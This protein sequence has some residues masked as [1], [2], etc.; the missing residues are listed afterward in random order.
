MKPIDP[1]QSNHTT[2]PDSYE[3]YRRRKLWKTI[4]NRVLSRD[5]Q[6]MRCTGKA[7]VVHHRSYAPEVMQGLADEYL[8]S[9]CHG[10]HTVVEFDDSGNYRPWQE[11]ESVLLTPDTGKDFPEPEVDLRRSYTPKPLGWERMSNLRQVG[12]YQRNSELLEAKRRK[13]PKSIV[14]YHTDRT[15]AEAAAFEILD[16]IPALKEK[17][18]ENSARLL[19]ALLTQGHQ[20]YGNDCALKSGLKPMNAKKEFDIFADLVMRSKEYGRLS[21]RDRKTMEQ[22]A[23]WN[24]PTVARDKRRSNLK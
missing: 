14:T 4:R 1:P 10:C 19:L 16:R 15:S 17:F 5:G 8:V 12:W 18:R 20:L 9:L 13:R 23:I 21:K 6:C 24:Q 3:K 11:E 22:V 7:E 2:P